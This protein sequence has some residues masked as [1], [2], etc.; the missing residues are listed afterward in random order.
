MSDRDFSKTIIVANG[1]VE[2]GVA[3]SA[4][5]AQITE[6]NLPIIAADGGADKALILDLHPAIVVGDMDSIESSTLAM[7]EARHARIL[8][9]HPDKDETDLELAIMEAVRCGAEWI[10]IIGGMGDRI[11]QSFGNISLL[12]ITELVG[13]DVALVSANQTLWVKGPGQHPLMGEVGDTISL[14]PLNENVTHITTHDLE[15]P[16]VDETLYVGPARGMSNVIS[17]ASPQVSFD[18]GHLLIVHTTG[19]A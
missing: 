5:I 11:D 7:L 16:L 18:S 1:S 10:R 9:F 17:G 13:L 12:Q 6:E 2:L 4:L 19:R 3:L 15:Y 14:L 8:R